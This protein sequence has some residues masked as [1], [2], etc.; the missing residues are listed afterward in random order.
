M[1]YLCA[2]KPLN[3]SK[4]NVLIMY[5]RSFKLR[6][7]QTTLLVLL[8]SSI[9]FSQCTITSSQGYSV[10]VGICPQSIVVSSTD[11]PNGYNYNVNIN[12][13]VILSGPNVQELYT[14][15]T[16][17]DCNGGQQN[18]YY[19]LPKMGGTGSAV[20]VTNPFINTDGGAYIYTTHPSCTQ[21]NVSNLN[22]ATLK[23]IIEGPG[24]PYQVIDCNCSTL[25]LPVE[26]LSFQANNGTSANQLVWK[27]ASE[28]RNK[29]FTIEA[30]S[31]AK[32]WEYI[33]DVA[34]VGNTIEMNTYEFHDEKHANKSTYYKLS[35]T[36]ED[37][38]RN[39]LAIAYVKKENGSFV[40][41]PN[42]SNNGRLN[43]SFDLAS[44]APA[45]VNVF[46]E[47]GQLVYSGE[48]SPEEMKMSTS[49]IQLDEK[50]GLYFVELSQNDEII[51]RTKVILL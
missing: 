18:G 6:T 44:N 37:G 46:N 19:S 7:I 39:E 45:S 4:I 35:Q 43:I 3:G 5:T 32:T 10:S 26:F 40:V 38:T 16:L 2:P 41:S 20:T 30:S 47:V 33:T 29:F 1:L 34:A 36:D 21:A 14:L 23:L 25:V 12:Y 42:P 17:I 9:G 31:D 15:Q 49:S 22:C 48:L 28:H 27:T 51:D 24:I 11:C 50:A 8:I 13:S